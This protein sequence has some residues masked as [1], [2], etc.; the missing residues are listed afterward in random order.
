MPEVVRDHEEHG[1]GAD[2]VERRH[3]A[4]AAHPRASC[5]SQ[6]CLPPP[7]H[8]ALS[9]EERPPEAGASGGR[10]SRIAPGCSCRAQSAQCVL[11][12]TAAEGADAAPKPLRFLAATV[13]V[14]V[15]PELRSPT[16]IDEWLRVFE[17]VWPP[18]LDVHVALY[19]KIDAPP[20]LAGGVNATVTL[21]SPAVTDVIVGAPGT[22][23]T[24]GDRVTTGAD[25]ADGGPN[26]LRLPASTLHVYVLPAVRLRTLVGDACSVVDRLAPPSLDVHAT[27]YSRIFEPPSLAGGEYVTVTVFTP[28]TTDVIVGAPGTVG[29]GGGDSVTTGADCA[30]GGP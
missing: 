11:V 10:R 8:M 7:C 16:R 25:S 27:L 30:E 9:H 21:W 5:P 26:P 12:V 22:V 23:M 3:E 1:D 4:E 20:L 17:R 6:S 14:Y 29:V 28:A 2:A 15:F 13:Q 18:L 24:G 19:K